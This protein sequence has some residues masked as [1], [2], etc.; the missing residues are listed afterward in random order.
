[1]ISLSLYFPGMT[2]G[3]GK[4]GE[5]L[6]EG[7]PGHEI[8]RNRRDRNVIARDRNAK[9]KAYRGLTR[10]NAD[11][12][13]APGNAPVHRD[14]SPNTGWRNASSQKLRPKAKNQEPRTKNQEL[15][16]KC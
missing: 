4:V 16:A 7:K 13:N 15:T 9:A 6:L 3:G 1:M 10:M 12:K 11:Q 2:G 8:A 5:R 14:V